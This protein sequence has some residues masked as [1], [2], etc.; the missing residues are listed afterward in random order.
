MIDSEDGVQCTGVWGVD[1]H[2]D[3]LLFVEGDR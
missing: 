1:I 2:R 3:E